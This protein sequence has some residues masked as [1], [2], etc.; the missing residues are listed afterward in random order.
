MS[1]M[2]GLKAVGFGMESKARVW[3]PG[4]RAF[5]TAHP[6]RLWRYRSLREDVYVVSCGRSYQGVG[7]YSF[8]HRGR[9]RCQGKLLTTGPREGSDGPAMLAAEGEVQTRLLVSWP[10]FSNTKPHGLQLSVLEGT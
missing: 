5:S 4:Q 8:I 7:S 1:E 9:T 10:L 2:D 6:S 3:T